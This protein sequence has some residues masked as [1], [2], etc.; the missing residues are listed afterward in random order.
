MDRQLC[1]ALYI[2]SKEIVHAYKRYLDPLHLTYTG[3]ITMLT[4]WHEDGLTVKALGDRLTLD[5]GTLT[6]LLKKLEALSYVRRCRST[7]DER[8][9]HIC[10]TDAGRSLR[11]QAGPIPAQVFAEVNM[12]PQKAA[13]LTDLLCWMSESLAKTEAGA[14]AYQPGD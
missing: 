2:G 6:P 1:Y 12:H 10:L 3:Y 13:R 7:D 9:V 5:S 8:N 14:Q 11:Q 4:L